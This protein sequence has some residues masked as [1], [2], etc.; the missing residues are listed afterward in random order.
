MK[1][2][3]CKEDKGNERTKDYGRKGDVINVI[4]RRPK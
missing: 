2:G 1:E 4:L 3:A